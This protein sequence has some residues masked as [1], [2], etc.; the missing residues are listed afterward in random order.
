MTFDKLQSH[1]IDGGTTVYKT[2]QL[3]SSSI[4][5]WAIFSAPLQCVSRS[6]FRKGA[7]RYIFMLGEHHLGWPLGLPS[8][9]SPLSSLNLPSWWFFPFPLGSL[10]P[11]D[12]GCHTQ[13][14][15]S[16]FSDITLPHCQTV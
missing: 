15:C 4:L 9:P 6:G 12:L 14:N 1:C 2:A 13:S 11:G 16:S 7:F 3:A 5:I 8:L 10:S